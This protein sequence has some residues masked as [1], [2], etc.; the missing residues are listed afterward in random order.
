M[1]AKPVRRYSSLL[2]DKLL[3]K[4]KLNSRRRNPAV[5]FPVFFPPKARPRPGPVHD[6]PAIQG[7]ARPPPAGLKE[8]GKH[9]FNLLSGSYQY[10]LSYKINIIN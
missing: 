6:L 4:I 3:A 1:P 9:G 2:R 10:L 5:I 8:R 7:G